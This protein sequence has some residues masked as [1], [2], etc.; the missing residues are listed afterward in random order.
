MP[1]VKLLQERR[2]AIQYL[3]CQRVFCE[4]SRGLG[5]RFY[6]LGFKD[7]TEKGCGKKGTHI[8]VHLAVQGEPLQ[9]LDH[10]SALQPALFGVV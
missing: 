10:S 3:H 2:K 7:Q 9:Q 5:F 1:I 4:Q 8:D 6:A